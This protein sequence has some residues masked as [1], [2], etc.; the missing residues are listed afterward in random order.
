M[1]YKALKYRNATDAYLNVLNHLIKSGN[2]VPSRLGN[3]KELSTVITLRNP[4]EVVPFVYGRRANHFGMLAESLWV[5]SDIDEV[6]MISP[7]NSRLGDF[8]DDGKTLYGAYGPRITS[9]I[10]GSFDQL[11][12]VIN[13]FARDGLDSRQA[14]ISILQPQDAGEVTK[15]FPCNNEVMFK[16]RDGKLNMTVMNRS[17]D[18]HWGLF[19]VNFPQFALLQNYV[20]RRIG[21]DMGVQ[22]HVSDS[23]HLYMESKPHQD[24]TWRMTRSGPKRFPFY[25][26]LTRNRSKP[27]GIFSERLQHFEARAI[28]EHCLDSD[29]S[30]REFG[31]SPF[32]SVT[33]PLLIL[34][35]RIKDGTI[36]REEAVKT[37]RSRVEESI[38]LVDP[39]P[40]SDFPA[41][42]VL[43]CYQT[44]CKQEQ[45]TVKRSKMIKVAHSDFVSILP[46]TNFQSNGIMNYLRES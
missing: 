45:N 38:K 18:I 39:I 11:N 22:T 9:P 10:N 32:L 28:F 2:D 25:D 8:S 14:V 42:W 41:D 20:A 19:G 30:T 7:W 35:R 1:E 36:D 34:Y 4:L 33:I 29:D 24:I 5:M 37:L 46:V 15:D 12:E 16:V 3:T 26:Y 21:V 6:E 13:T 17:N 27:Y 44:L 31:A 43:A 23:L 40:K